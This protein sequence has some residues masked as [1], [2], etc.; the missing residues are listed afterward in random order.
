MEFNFEFHQV[1]ERFCSIAWF[2]FFEITKYQDGRLPPAYFLPTNVV[3][4]AF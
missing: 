2:Y 1:P 3:K 4:D